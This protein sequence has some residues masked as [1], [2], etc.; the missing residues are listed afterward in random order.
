EKAESLV[1]EFRDYIEQHRA[2]I[3]ALQILYSRP[4]KQRLTEEGLKELE[5]KLKQDPHFGPDPVPRLWNAY[6]IQN[7]KAATRNPVGRFTDLVSLAR[8]A[9]EQ[10]PILEPFEE[11]VKQSFATWLEAKRAA[12]ISF[13]PEQLAWLEKMRD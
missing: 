2:E 12:G 4:F 1:R 11:H 8:F 13:E 10:E 3:G 5:A 7:P 9:L 6:Q